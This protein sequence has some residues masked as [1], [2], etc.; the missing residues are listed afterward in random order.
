MIKKLQE[1]VINGGVLSN[2]EAGWLA[3]QAEKDDLYKAA[4]EITKRCC[5]KKFDLCSIINAKSGQ[6]PEN[7][8]W[9]AQ[10]VHHKTEIE[11]Y[12]LLPETV[13]LKHALSSESKNIGRF[14]L[15]TSGR[16]PNG[17]ELAKIA[18]VYR[19][20]SGHSQIY[21]CGSLGLLGKEELQLLQRA[22]MQR[23]HCNLETAPSYF[24]E[25]CTTHTQEQKIETIRGAQEIG[26]EVCSGGIIGMGES[27]E[28]RIELAFKLRE[29]QIES[30]PLNILQPIPNTPLEKTPSLSDEEILTTVA[31]FRFINPKAFLRF[32]GGRAQL[33]AKLQQEAMRIGI[34]SA[35]AGDM[36]TTT[37]SKIEE[38]KRLIEQTGYTL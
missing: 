28:Q 18:S 10:S 7:C 9:C 31:L 16:K 4:G 23:Y 30:I 21:L 19:H 22:G 37:G 1:R 12:G 14:S 34:N 25:L 15:V 29:L 26:L 32:A 27:M 24:S 17:T 5:S 38:D 13:C 35:I 6:C 36:L 8:K 33:S 20:I 2:D 11:L 3:F